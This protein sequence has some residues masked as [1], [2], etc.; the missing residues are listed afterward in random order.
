MKKFS[1]RKALQLGLASAAASAGLAAGYHLAAPYFKK[2]SNPRENVLL[3][4]S[5]AMRGDKIGK[6]VGGKEVTPNLNR[7]ARENVTFDQAYSTCGWTKPSLAAILT[8]EHPV[9]TGVTAPTYTLPPNVETMQSFLSK[10][11]YFT[12]CVQTSNFLA[13]ETVIARDKLGPFGFGRDF[14]VYVMRNRRATDEDKTRGK[15]KRQGSDLVLETFYAD[16]ELVNETFEKI[17]TGSGE[18]YRGMRYP[19]FGYVHYMDTHQP[20]LPP[21]PVEGITGKFYKDYLGKEKSADEAFREYSDVGISNVLFNKDGLHRS[22][23]TSR[24]EQA[25]MRAINDEAAA[26]VDMCVGRLIESLQGKGVYDDTTLIFTADHGD[27]LFEFGGLGHGDTYNVVLHVPLIVKRAG[28]AHKVVSERVSNASVFTTMREWYGAG[29]PAFTTQHSLMPHI[30]GTDTHNELIYAIGNG[31]NGIQEKV[32]LPDGREATLNDKKGEDR[33]RD[34][35]A[36]P[37]EK[38][39][40]P[41]DKAVKDELFRQK[42]YNTQYAAMNGV[43]PTLTS[44]DWQL[45]KGF[46]NTDA[47]SP[48]Q[49]A[50]LE[51]LGYI[52]H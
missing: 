4:V 28:L 30:N 35:S 27:Q 11:G 48:E 31:K 41:E 42:A 32:I 39:P 20:W 23:E 37:E 12:F 26:Y 49:K 18:L 9:Y 13:P 6:I 21:R 45:G 1:R 5:D 33:Y 43:K 44:H 40:L 22:R 25:L 47:M 52:G 7:L 38:V 2:R 8:G 3:I 29:E 36:D 19:F 15:V 51:A 16:G 24:E 14:D 17:V 46:L 10:R 50:Q 34:M